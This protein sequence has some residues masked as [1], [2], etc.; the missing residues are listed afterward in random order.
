MPASG[1]DLNAFWRFG[2]PIVGPIARLLFGIHVTGLERIPPGPA[3]LAANHLSALDGPILAIVVGSRRRRM[4]RFLV[5]AEFFASRWVGWILR[6]GG[7]IPL[8]RGVRDAGAIADAVLTVEAGGLAGIF[9]EGSVNPNVD[10]LERVRKGAARIALSAGAPV[11][12]VGIWG[13]HER[14]PKAGLRFTR[15]LRTPVRFAL[16]D[17]I[18]LE[19]DPESLERIEAFTS[20][21]AVAIAEQVTEARRLD[22]MH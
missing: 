22:R 11:I 9:P 12:P 21:I 7:Q 19:G 8:R 4:V 10:R 16:G 5:A 20:R 3:I 2:L 1:D 14:W 15:P 6:L 13:T 17:P 18:Q